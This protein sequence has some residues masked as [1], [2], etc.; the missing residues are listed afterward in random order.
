MSLLRTYEATPLM[1]L[2]SIPLCVAAF[3]VPPM[4][5]DPRTEIEIVVAQRLGEAFSSATRL[6]T[7]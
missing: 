3:A 5:D 7:S 4:A 1:R 2:G 6:T